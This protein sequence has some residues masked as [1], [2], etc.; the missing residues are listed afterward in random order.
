MEESTTAMIKRWDCRI[1][2]SKSGIVDM[3][4]DDELKTLSADII[5]RACFGSSY[6]F[7]NQIFEK[8]ADMV[9][10]YGKPSLQFGFLNFSWLANIF[11]IGLFDLLYI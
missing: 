10:V 8:I 2:E 9:E 1:L 6:S 5:S 3:E 7:G 4:I 11:F